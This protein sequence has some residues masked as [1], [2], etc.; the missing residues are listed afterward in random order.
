M[1]FNPSKSYTFLSSQVATPYMFEWK[2]VYRARL[3]A[4][5]HG[6][7]PLC[8]HELLQAG[9]S[10]E[11]PFSYGHRKKKKNTFQIPKKLIAYLWTKR[12]FT[13]WENCSFGFFPPE[14]LSIA[15]SN[16][17]G[18]TDSR[19]T[20]RRS[21]QWIVTTTCIRATWSPSFQVRALCPKKEF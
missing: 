17:P 12:S 16:A 11:P 9:L 5:Y 15:S 10:T 8:F 4:E 1:N 13:S 2:H 20:E 19:R 18:S 21:E 6:W 3:A 7:G 14:E